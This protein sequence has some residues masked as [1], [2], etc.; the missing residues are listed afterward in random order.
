[1]NHPSPK[2]PSS[3]VSPALAQPFAGLTPSRVVDAICD[4]GFELDGRIQSLSSYEN[5]V[6]SLTM[7]GEE[8]ACVAKFYRPQRW[9][10][11]QIKEEH[12]FAL[13]LQQA[14]I[15]V[16]APWVVKGKTLH[17][18]Q[19]TREE[20]SLDEEV[21]QAPDSK[22]LSMDVRFC[23]YP[24]KGGR[25]P[26]LEDPEVLEWIGRYL[27][28]IHT[29]G[30]QQ[31][32]EHRATLNPQ[33]MGWEPRHFLLSQDFMVE[34]Q[35]KAWALVSERAIVQTERLFEIVNP[36]FI[37]VH[38]DCHPGN[39]LWT[40]VGDDHSGGPHFVDL[41]DARMAPSVQDLWMLM[42]GSQAERVLAESC[43]LEGYESMRAFDRK[44]LRLI[45]ALRTLRMIHY[46]A[47]LG[48]RVKDPAFAQHFAWFGSESYWSEQ[49]Q[50][51]EDQCVLMD[52]ELSKE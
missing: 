16:V 45:E 9:S 3:N 41:D 18:V 52:E 24:K 25:W 27:A 14:E 5:R 19:F 38:G 8:R 28:R 49:I 32:F 11:E 15:P 13:E 20:I 10:D 42:G 51:L 47:W 1:M 17:H 34:H 37:R 48:A 23:V 6:Y 36:V 26:E 7:E 21:A 33:T 35:Q 22:G 4:L 50:S 43:L 39:I 29:V 46:S 12:D 2:P 40:P 44:E 30:A 31:A